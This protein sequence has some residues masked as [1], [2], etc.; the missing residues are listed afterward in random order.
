V[1]R[2]GEDVYTYTANSIGSNNRQLGKVMRLALGF[3]MG[4]AK[5][6]DTA[7]KSRIKLTLAEAMNGVNAFRAANE[8]IVQLWHGCE[9]QAK[10]AIWNPGIEYTFRRLRFR[11]A[12]PKRKLA[13]A[14]LMTLPSGRNLVYRDVRIDNN[15]IRFWGV[16]QYRK[17]WCE[18]KTYGGKLV[19][20][21]TQ[22]VARDLLAEAIVV[23]DEYFPDTLC[24]TVHDEVIAATRTE[25]APHLLNF[26]ESIMSSPPAWASGMPLSCKG[27]IAER[28]AKL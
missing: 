27:V 15:E 19:E 25:N 7:A 11:M 14:L 13:R 26:M 10:K 18:L 23:I 4:A 12:D 5:F 22:A 28:Y 24:T 21:A 16:D 8:P 2:R 6:Q 3:G 9:N 1:F 17:V 20:N